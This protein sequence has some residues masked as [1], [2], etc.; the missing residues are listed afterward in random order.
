MKAIFKKSIETINYWLVILELFF[1]LIL[2]LLESYDIAVIVW[3][4]ICFCSVIWMILD[5][6]DICMIQKHDSWRHVTYDLLR[7]FIRGMTIIILYLLTNNKIMS[8]MWW[9]ASIF[10]VVIASVIFSR[11]YETWEQF[12]DKYY[13]QRKTKAFNKKI[14]ILFIITM[15]TSVFLFALLTDDY[16]TDTFLKQ[17]SKGDLSNILSIL[18]QEKKPII[19]TVYYDLFLH[20]DSLFD[21]TIQISVL[22]ISCFIAIVSIFKTKIHGIEISDLYCWFCTRTIYFINQIIPFVLIGMAY[23][24]YVSNYLLTLLLILFYYINISAIYIYFVFRIHDYTYFKGIVTKRIEKEEFYLKCFSEDHDLFSQNN[25]IKNG[26]INKFGDKMLYF[27]LN[28]IAKQGIEDDTTI[29]KLFKI[30][31]GY[32]KLRENKMIGSTYSLNK[33]DMFA[34]GLI[35]FD[36]L[37][38]LDLENKEI[39]DCKCRECI[40]LVKSIHNEKVYDVITHIT[41]VYFALTVQFHDMQYTELIELNGSFKH[42]CQFRI[43]LLIILNAIARSDEVD[44]ENIRKSV[45]YLSHSKNTIEMM[46][47]D[48]YSDMFTFFC[49]FWKRMY[50]EKDIYLDIRET[51]N[52]C[53]EYY[54]NLEVINCGKQESMFFVCD[55]FGKDDR[56]SC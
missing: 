46:N 14:I 12:S 3:K 19:F 49:Y 15:F 30:I 47:F 34:I 51:S 36:F 41:L 52:T 10:I 50:L 29:D 5:F 39:N 33:H 17:Y 40:K 43:S 2:V 32:I 35:Y 4:V 16:L 55:E 27:P 20:I 45:A 11:R 44:I 48:E 53:E 42:K 22:Y 23:I 7:I 37:E 21:F 18:D 25:D 6:V 1:C 54:V 38:S 24:A 56:S 9:F 31:K 26:D 13:F 28:I 8:K